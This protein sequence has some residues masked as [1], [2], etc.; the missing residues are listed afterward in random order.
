MVSLDFIETEIKKFREDTPGCRERIHLNNAGAALMPHVVTKAMTDYLELEERIGGYESADKMS[1]SINEFYVSAAKL[2]NCKPGEIAFTA[3]ATDSF[4]RA[5]SSIPFQPGDV[6]LT[7][8]EDY[9][10]NQITY[11]SFQKRFGIKLVRVASHASGGI[12]LDDLE[13]CIKKYNPKLVAI[14]HIPTNS[15]LIQPA[16]AIGTIC[17]KYGVLYLLDACQSVGQLALDVQQLNCDFLSVTSR[18][19][20]RGP[21]GAGFLFVSQ[22]VLDKGFEPLFIDMRGADWVEADKYIPRK[23]AT[24]F[25]DWEFAY[26][27]VMGTKAAIDYCL[28]LDMNKIEYRVKH[29]ADYIRT[30]LQEIKGV[31][32]QDK[33]PSLAGLVTF[34]L[35]GSDPVF[36]KKHMLMKNIN[37]VTSVRNYAVIDY[38]E[39]K[40]DWT[41]RVSPHYY[42]TIEEADQLLA[43]V[44]ELK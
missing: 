36:I 38:D 30:H 25:E 23:D 20:L 5:I 43:E 2:L 18:K 6:I 21:R 41:I 13:A 32:T 40:V 28:Q 26:A 8:N 15:G 24:R 3:N 31:S 1:D 19:F 35:K 42:N 44:K 14:T 39:K 22:R 9:I 4:C 33:G 11:L 27:L 34:H 29:L 16:E 10:S 37:V 17:K 7:S 12:D